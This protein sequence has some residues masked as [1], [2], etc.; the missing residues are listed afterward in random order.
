MPGFISINSIRC[1]A[2]HF[3]LDQLACASQRIALHLMHVIAHI[4]L[5]FWNILY[6]CVQSLPATINNSLQ[7]SMVTMSIRSKSCKIRH[8][9]LEWPE[10]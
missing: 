5:I 8:H 2:A 7:S 4:D 3:A 10:K 6:F 1:F 9:M